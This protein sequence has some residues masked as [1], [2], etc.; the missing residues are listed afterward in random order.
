MPE[1]TPKPTMITIPE[2][3]LR[4]W[5]KHVALGMDPTV[6]FDD[7]ASKMK[8]EAYKRR[9]EELYFLNHRIRSFLPSNER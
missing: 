4:D 9:G 8:D 5:L 2:I 3:E 6:K 7:D 1:I